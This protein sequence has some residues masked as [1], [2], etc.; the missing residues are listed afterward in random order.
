MAGTR[1]I[2]LPNDSVINN[3]DLF[4]TST[5]DGN[6]RTI[7]GQTLINRLSGITSASNNGTGLNIYNTNLSTETNLVFNKLTTTGALSASYNPSGSVLLSIKPSSITSDLIAENTIKSGDIQNDAI[8]A[9]NIGYSGSVLQMR[10][11]QD[12]LRLGT[13]STTWS[14]TNF[15]LAIT[16]VR[17]NSR[18]LIRCNLLLGSY[19]SW[20]Y[21][22]IH[23]YQNGSFSKDLTVDGTRGWAYLA[24][25][26]WSYTATPICIEVFDDPPS[27]GWSGAYTYYLVAKNGTGG[28]CNTYIG[29]S[30]YWY[31]TVEPST[32]VMSPTTMTITELHA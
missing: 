17:A 7:T 30:W 23:R 28:D 29:G 6:T 2:D 4:L 3:D 12:D 1:I 16:P 26:N 27:G 19:A 13:N 25:A 22:T 21:V 15:G 24:D 11:T 9:L 20:P 10:V 14:N 8:G 32:G 5:A 18:I 31:S